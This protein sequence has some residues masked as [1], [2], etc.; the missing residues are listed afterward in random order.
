MTA[1]NPDAAIDYLIIGG[2]LAGATAAEELR[3]QDA[4]GRIV[5][6]SND[7][8]LPYHRPPLSKEYLRSEIEADG[9]YGDGGV[10]VQK[11]EWFKEQQIEVITNAEATKLDTR[12]RTVHISNG[13]TLHFESL[14]LATGGRPR[15]LD[16]PGADL[17]GVHLLRT[18]ND[19]DALRGLI[20]KGT[21][22]VV[23]GSGFIGME[24]AASALTKG[25]QVTIVEPQERPWA[26]LV[27][28]EV[29]N[30]FSQK[31]Q[32]N[33]ADLR[34][35][36]AAL[37]FTAGSD[38]KVNNVRIAPTS[39]KNKTEDIPCDLVIAGIGIQLNTEIA[40]QAGLDVD[41]R[42]G[43]VVDEH[44]ETQVEDIFAAGDVAA[45]PDPIVGLMHFEHWDNALSSAQT[46]ANNMIGRDLPYRHIPYFFSDQFDISVNM[47]GY[48]SNKLQ[49]IVRGDIK[50]GKF[51][52]LYID[53]GVLR[54]A[55][56]VN[57]DEQM[58][59]WRELIAEEVSVPD[60]G[61]Q[62]ADP[63]FDIN[64]LKQA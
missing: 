52:A 42:H 40:Q 6:V 30:F 10:Y 15:Q 4:K 41:K 39:D 64:T 38:G 26:S 57:D 20:N 9:T 34:Y 22:I 48:P 56:M 8:K 49:T 36:H 7:N 23:V 50:A 25:A 43:I 28:E 11:P 16:L 61:S 33:G 62:L 2:G 31:F 54:A 51:T 58:D 27:S 46:V 32:Q 59:V 37:A 63:S 17:K 3:K 18:L 29:A 60:N 24:V 19:A 45:Y 14:L 44:L 35:S 53:K 1:Q 21:R 12:A 47:L 5:L 13:Q 55:L